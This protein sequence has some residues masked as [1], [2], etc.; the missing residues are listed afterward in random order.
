MVLNRGIGLIAVVVIA[1]MCAN[2]GIDS[3]GAFGPP[4]IKILS[5]E[6][7]VSYPSN[8]IDLEVAANVSLVNWS[9]SLNGAAPI[10]FSPNTQH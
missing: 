10:S 8:E 2:V 4:E 1:F 5:P 9:Y 7:G 3:A 6:E